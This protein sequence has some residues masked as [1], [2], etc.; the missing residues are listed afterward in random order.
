MPAITAASHAFIVDSS[1]ILQGAICFVH[2]PPTYQAYD[3]TAVFMQVL[4]MD[5]RQRR[6]L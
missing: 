3:L 4:H 5:W 1:G 2:E 6:G